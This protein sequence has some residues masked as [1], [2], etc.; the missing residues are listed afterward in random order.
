M[1]LL[2]LVSIPQFRTFGKNAQ[3]KGTAR[4]VKS[5]EKTR[6]FA[7]APRDE[8]KNIKYYRIKIEKSGNWTI[9]S[10]QKTGETNDFE[11][12]QINKSVQVS[13][14]SYNNGESVSLSEVLLGFQT[15]SGAT[16]KSLNPG[17]ET[18]KIGFNYINAGSII[19]TLEV[20]LLTSQAE[21]LEN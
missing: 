17:K 15:P 4:E 14:F 20:N 19:S 13:S 21:I 11:K 8:D 12:G 10:V 18:L 2:I 3:T 7:M 5:L 16:V 9:S 6:T 1:V